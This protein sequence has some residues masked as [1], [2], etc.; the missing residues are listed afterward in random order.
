MDNLHYVESVLLH[1]IAPHQRPRRFSASAVVVDD[2][3]GAF[4]LME[5]ETIYM[6]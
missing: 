1:T 3:D 5:E 4:Y 2:D 6:L